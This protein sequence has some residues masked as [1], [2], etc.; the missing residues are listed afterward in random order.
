MNLLIPTLARN[1]RS[2]ADTDVIDHLGQQKMITQPGL[3]TN[4]RCPVRII[5]PIGRREL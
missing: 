1:A 5:V 4:R 2:N 3:V